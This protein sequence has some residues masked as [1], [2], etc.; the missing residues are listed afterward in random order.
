MTMHFE[1]ESAEGFATGAIG[2]PGERTFYVQVRA[3]GRVISVKCE[4]Q[5]VAEMANHLRGML[6]D[7]PDPG[8][9]PAGSARL[10]SPVEQDF[11]LGAIGLGMDR[12]SMRMVVQLEEAV[13]LDLD[14]VDV[15]DD[16][17][18]E[19]YLEEEHA[20]A[21]TVRVILDAAQARAF[22]EVADSVVGAGRPVCRW[23][24]GPM[25]PSGHACPKMN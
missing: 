25:E 12:A 22:C 13:V 23:C 21:S 16:D 19:A 11:V 10:A 9:A 3:E 14:E 20:R 5:Q 4:K 24:G 17:A 8:P 2:N 6:N 18:M 7:L 1:F 15:D